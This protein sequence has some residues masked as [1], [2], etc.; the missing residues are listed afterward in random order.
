MYDKPIKTKSYYPVS[1]DEAKRHLRVDDDWDKDD[2]YIRNLIQAAT[3]KCEEYIGK[4]IALTANITKVHDF[5]GC[6][7]Y[8]E[9]GN[10]ISLDSVRQ[11]DAST[12]I[13]VDHTETY[14]NRVYIELSS[15]A[16]QDP[17]YLYYTTGFAAGQCPALIKQAVLVKIGDLYD[18]ERQSYSDH[19]ENYAYQRLLDSFKIVLY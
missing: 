4:D 1:L 6:D 3:Q 14:Y 19:K 15:H 10:F 5:V 7:L 12:L 11:S 17:L 2:D 18:V 13:A 8:L 9:E 16:D